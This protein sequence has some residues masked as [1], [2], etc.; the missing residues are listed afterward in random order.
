MKSGF[1][2]RQ[3]GGA[4]T[5]IFGGFALVALFFLITEHRAHLYGFL[6]FLLL[7]GC[8]VMHL[9]HGHGGHGGHGQAPGAP[10][11]NDPAAPAAHHHH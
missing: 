8:V 10:G 1:S 7:G 3:H 6:P 5:W 4:S 11:P 2:S 9:F